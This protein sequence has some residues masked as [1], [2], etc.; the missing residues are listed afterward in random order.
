MYHTD[1]SACQMF[2]SPQP[3]ETDITQIRIGTMP[4]AAFVMTEKTV[5]L[6]I[7]YIAFVTLAW[8][9]P[10]TYMVQVSASG[11]SSVTSL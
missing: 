3:V 10:V 4:T 5:T 1:R 7:M 11:G 6:W 8:S 2:L 9:T